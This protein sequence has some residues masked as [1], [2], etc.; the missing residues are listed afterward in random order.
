MGPTALL[1][2]PKEG[3]LRIFVALNLVGKTKCIQIFGGKHIFKSGHLEDRED[4]A[5]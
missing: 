2:P 1:A 5:D 4:C 3:V